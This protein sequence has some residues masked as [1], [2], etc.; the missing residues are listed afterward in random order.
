MKQCNKCNIT[1]D[2]NHQYC[3]LCHQ[4]LIGEDTP[5]FIELYP[6]RMT[7]NREK[8]SVIRR[9]L[10]FV[11]IMGIL[12]LA[13][14]NYFDFTGDYWAVIPIISVIYL[15][16]F[17]RIGI[18]SFSNIAL[19]IT[20]LA[21][22]LIAVLLVIDYQYVPSDN[23]W[24]LDY[25]TPFLLLGSSITVA[26]ITWIRHVYYRDYI[27]YLLILMLLSVVPFTLIFFGVITVTWPSIAAFGYALFVL[28]FLIF[29]LPRWIK[30]EL[31]K[32]F[33]A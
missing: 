15:Y 18:F 31:S 12:L 8:Y 24:A 26:I 29:F 2:T 9:V 17:L 10:L 23:G 1:I 27:T 13:M 33:H 30:D 19:R 6:D 16:L 21:V 7:L 28:L 22:L 32:R 20:F 4:A 11:L 14:I 3:P 25:L 5:N